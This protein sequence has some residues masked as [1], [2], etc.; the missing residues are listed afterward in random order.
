MEINGQL[1][2]PATLLSGGGVGFRYPL[3]TRLNGLQSQFG[4]CDGLKMR[5]LRVELTKTTFI[6]IVKLMYEFSA[7][8]PVSLSVCPPVYLTSKTECR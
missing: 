5:E 4:C 1:H 6:S 7:E 3:N 2:T 8:W